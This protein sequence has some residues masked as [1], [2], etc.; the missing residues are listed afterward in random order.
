MK[1]HTF[2]H[3]PVNDISG[4][5]SEYYQSEFAAIESA[6][7]S[8]NMAGLIM[9]RFFI[10]DASI[11]HHEILFEYPG[12]LSLISDANLLSKYLLSNDYEDCSESSYSNGS[13]IFIFPLILS[14]EQNQ[15]LGCFIFKENQPFNDL[16][17]SCFQRLSNLITETINL[18]KKEDLYKYENS[19]Y[20]HLFSA[21]PE[22]IAVLDDNNRIL[23]VNP[24]FERLF[25]YKKEEITGLNLDE[26]I[27]P[28]DHLDEART[29][30]RKNWEGQKVAI[31]TTRLRRDG[32]I[33]H[34]SIL[35]VPF[36][37]GNGHFRVFGIYRDISDRIAAEK[38]KQSRL[39]L[40]ESL[41]KFSIEIINS[42]TSD[43]D[44]IIE[45]LLKVVATSNQAERA[46]IVR[47]R[48]AE[49]F[50]EITHEW[51]DDPAYSHKFRQPF[52]PGNEI[53]NYLANLKNGKIFNFTRAETKHIEGASDAEFYMD[54]LNIEALVNIPLFSAHKF[55]GYIG[56]DT[57]SRPVKWEEQHLN[58]LKLT[59]QI[60]LSA[61][62]RK[63]TD[64]AL[65]QAL[66]QAKASDK[67]KS[68]FL[69]GISHEI[70]TPMNHI[71]GFIELLSEPDI[72]LAEKSDFIEIM[73][74]SG[75]HLL[76][77]IDDVIE[78]AMIDSGQVSLKEDRCDLNRFLQSLFYE[79]D[80]LKTNYGKNN[81][82]IILRNNPVL[83]PTIFLSDE[84]RLKQM[85][86]NLISNAVKFTEI[87]SVEFWCNIIENKTLEIVVSDTGIGIDPADQP[88]VFD[89][90]HR[91][92]N[93]LTRQFGG[94]GLGLCISQSLAKLFGGKI[95]L[96][97]VPGK[98]ST[99][100]ITI[101]Y[102][103]YCAPVFQGSKT[104]PG[105]PVYNWA[106]KHILMVEDDPVNMRFLT[107]LLLKTNAV[108]HYAS[109]GQ[110]AIEM[111]QKQGFDI[112]LMDMDLPLVNGFDA[113]RRIKMMRPGIPVIAQTAHAMNDDRKDC[114][115][116]GCDEF[117]AKPIDK[118]LL[119]K[120]IESF[121][122]PAK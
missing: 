71:L 44:P 16:E 45:Q 59:G 67:L 65:Q 110:E 46:Y 6:V 80:A 38:Q 61:L 52:I 99:F 47:Y 108:L 62:E 94:A 17:K 35:G 102:K 42:E 119:Y 107:V 22:A 48:E 111:V 90:F 11:V 4:P 30:T 120:S 8:F 103:P 117:I 39:E 101:P 1:N 73:K 109:N 79:A 91:L 63:Q 115:D 27:A 21:A 75:M 84:S 23:D 54:L 92:D 20:S 29:L 85:V 64:E 51:V 97:S 15:L 89:R 53:N 40:I 114:M 105:L 106:G 13:S 113:T 100:S 25:L 10:K 41:S 70:R 58:A 3:F 33:I 50:V 69:A 57:Y 31:E 2:N 9:G 72:S 88:A 68:A 77:L 83:R 86:F 98:G 118:N 37:H 60:I 32:K 104:T 55:Y 87:G 49:H 56:L 7:R 116:A 34:V 36:E 122:N 112:V 96:E 93:N 78:L 24:E 14:K 95:T 76:R 18:R 5:G 81:I 82:K 43:V 19:K 26:L 66:Q 28:A 74:S 12:P 121:L